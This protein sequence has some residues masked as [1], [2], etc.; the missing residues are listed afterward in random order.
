MED[1]I[2][3][4]NC[5]VEFV[6]TKTDNYNNDITYFKLLD[7]NIDQKYAAVIKTDSKLP[8]FKTDKQAYIL[9]VKPKYINKNELVKD[10]TYLSDI[11]FK[12]YTYNDIEGYYV[13]HLDISNLVPL[14]DSKTNQKP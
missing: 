11:T 3:I 5:K 12:N 4:K 14:S 10:N 9:K 6:T 7:K 13:S 8:W 2:L 1:K